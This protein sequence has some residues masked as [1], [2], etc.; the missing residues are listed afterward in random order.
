MVALHV[1]GHQINLIVSNYTEDVAGLWWQQLKIQEVQLVAVIS[2]LLLISGWLVRQTLNC[3]LPL[4][5]W[6]PYVVWFRSSIVLVN[7]F[8][9]TLKPFNLACPL[10]IWHSSVSWVMR[11]KRETMGTAWRLEQM[12]GNSYGRVPQEAFEIATERSGTAMMVWLF[13]ETWHFSS[14]VGTG[15]S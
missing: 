15:R 5:C 9:F 13:K 12:E 10:Y 8:V 7:T 14:Q 3:Y 6:L 4:F 2:R 11:M 1:I